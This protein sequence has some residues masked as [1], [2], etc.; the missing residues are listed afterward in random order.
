MKL[1]GGQTYRTQNASTC[2]R[3]ISGN[4]LV[5]IVP[6][7]GDISGK[8]MFLCTVSEG[9]MIPFLDMQMDGKCW[10]FQLAALEE[11]EIEIV[12]GGDSLGKIRESFAGQAG[13]YLF[14]EAQFQE[15]MIEK[16]NMA[17]M[18][19]EAYVYA[20][21]QERVRSIGNCR[22]LIQENL[23]GKETGKR[24]RKEQFLTNKDLVYQAV[25]VLAGV[26]GFEIL[27]LEKLKERFPRGMD[28]FQIA[29]ACGIPARKI[30][31]EPGW[32]KKNIGPFLGRR[33]QDHS[34]V[35]LLPK[36]NGYGLYD[37][38]T[39]ETQKVGAKEVENIESDGVMFY[40]S[41]GKDAVAMRDLLVFGLKETA[42]ANWIAVFFLTILG[43]FAALLI[44][45]SYEYLTEMLL[46]SAD[47][48]IILQFAALIFLCMAGYFCISF[49]KN[50]AVYGNLNQIQN[51]V[52][53][54]VYDRLMHLSESEIRNY[55]S[56]DLAQ[57]AI[58]AAEVFRDAF[59][60]II[61]AL[62]SLV[63]AVVFGVRI[64]I[65][66]WNIGLG[67]LLCMCLFGA[68]SFILCRRHVKAEKKK[69]KEEGQLNSLMFQFLCGIQKIR[70]DG[71][72][73]RALYEYLKKYTRMCRIEMSQSRDTAWLEMF[74]RLYSGLTLLILFVLY[75]AHIPVGSVGQFVGLLTVVELF[76]QSVVD[77]VSSVVQA[78]FVLPLYDRCR[79]I[80]ESSVETQKGTGSVGK[81]EGRIEASNVSFSYNEEEGSVLH[82]LSF[83]VEPG[84]YIGIVGTSGCGKSTLLQILLGFERP[85]KGCVFYDHKDLE[86]L[87][88]PELRKKLGVVLQDESLFTG[89]IYENI[90]ASVPGMTQDQ[91][92]KLL[93]EVSLRDEVEQMPM[94]LHT[95]V[96]ES[97][98]TI[99]GGQRQRILLAR[100]LAGNPSILFLDEA[101]SALDNEVQGKIIKMLDK[102]RM[103]RIVIAHRVNTV[104]KCHRI[105]VMDHGE[106]AEEG[107]YDELLRKKGMFYELAKRQMAS[108][109]S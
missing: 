12:G 107:T 48:G 13:V 56:A 78:D 73:D 91:A 97:G 53:A 60:E 47:Y 38:Q 9:G 96:T 102:K 100:A 32:Q 64:L 3:V 71:M 18:K 11:A 23:A 14:E 31:L 99:S 93:D 27:P 84:E 59:R 80:L 98:N 58:K 2:A 68:A 72:E 52:M 57:R 36:A 45:Q 8:K 49:V 28:A 30:R 42:A 63:F 33:K 83:R 79:P 105:F 90:S 10:N 7:E 21:A 86:Q 29:S 15:E 25:S 76:S 4:L 46:V 95:L 1:K 24:K 65:Y 87:G 88:K 77:V 92:W 61:G 55:D 19:E 51:A 62:I 82:D 34:P 101:T 20:S 106:I 75:S 104:K 103:T 81:L 54:A 37:V 6:Y 26:Q 39:G 43:A 5:Y 109:E 69:Q 94:G 74:S 22:N 67:I 85:D 16:Y 17:M 44:P 66:D 50:F 89:S 70:T 41:F 35:V 40:R 108:V